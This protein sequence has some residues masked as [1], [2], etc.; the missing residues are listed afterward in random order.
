MAYD[1]LA[2]AALVR[3]CLGAAPL[4]PLGRIA[5]SA[6][7]HPHTITPALKSVDGN[8][9]RQ[10]QA[11]ALRDR[12]ARVRTPDPLGATKAV[13]FDVG[14]GHPSSLARRIRRVRT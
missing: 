14:Y 12:V 8:T 2:L 13:A 3:E 4:T 9:Y 6:R 10:V 11:A 7:V 5:A 1:P